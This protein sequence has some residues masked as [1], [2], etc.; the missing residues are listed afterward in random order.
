MSMK[1]TERG[2]AVLVIGHLLFAALTALAL[3][4]WR[5][6]AIHVDSAWQLFKWLQQEGLSFEAHR[7]SA[8]FPQIAVKFL[9]R[10]HAGLPALLRTASMAH[11]L[12]PWGLFAVA[13]HV[14]RR[15]WHAAAMALA[16]VLCTRI[17]F[18]GMVLEAHYLLSYPLLLAAALDA[19]HDRRSG[20][21]LVTA[22]VALLLTLFAHPLGAPVACAMILFQVAARGIDRLAIALFIMAAIFPVI[23]HAVWPATRYEQGL[24]SGIAEGTEAVIS[25]SNPAVDFLFGHSWRDTSTYLPW[26]CLVGFSTAL[27]LKRGRWLL[28]VLLL[29][30]V[31]AFLVVTFATYH[32]GD[33]AV[34]MEKNFLPLATLVAL[35]LASLLREA[36]VRSGRIAALMLLIIGFM[37]FRGM[38]FAAREIGPRYVLIEALVGE[39][40][41]GHGHLRIDTATLNARGLH[42]H[43]ALPVEALL[44]SALDGA[45][46]AV[47][48]TVQGEGDAVG[49][50]IPLDQLDQ[51]WF[52]PP[53]AG[54]SVD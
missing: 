32:R 41:A 13:G 11:V 15:P 8:L 39:A 51:R 23:A 33:S 37:Q 25:A 6:R 9:S 47:V 4:H 54:D 1:H 18:Y 29:A 31:G 16:A 46:R 2:S 5:L 22:W 52:R 48:L 42:V 49:L 50:P 7:Y 3:V 17:A 21:P 10:L 30:S 35:P 53:F 36:D 24:Y 43:W 44:C 34:M 45:E 26:W 38:A 14:L 28:L 19:W 40:R 20:A 27:L 12:L